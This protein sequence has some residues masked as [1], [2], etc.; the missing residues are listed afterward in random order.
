MNFIIVHVILLTWFIITS[1]GERWY[2]ATIIDKEQDNFIKTYNTDYLQAQDGFVPLT[3]KNFT[4]AIGAD[5]NKWNSKKKKHTDFNYADNLSTSV[6]AR[7]NAT[8]ILRYMNNVRIINVTNKKKPMRKLIRKR[9]R[10]IRQDKKLLGAGRAK[11]LEVFE[12][13]EF[14]HV[15]C[16]SSSGLEGTCLPEYECQNA[17][18]RPMGTCADGY[19]TCCVLEFKCDDRTSAAS[20]WFTNPSFPSPSTERL[21]CTLMIDKTSE[22]V[23]Q[24][25][26][27]FM[28]FE[29]LPP[30]DG[31]CQQ[32]QFIVSGQ[33]VNNVIPILCGVNT[34]Q[35]IYIEVAETDG[36]INLSFQT[37]SADTR[38]FSIKISQLTETDEL[39]GPTGCFQYFTEPQGILES[40]NYRDKSD[41]GIARIPEYLNNLNYAM[42]IN[43]ATQTCSITYTNSNYNMQIV[44]YDPDG[45]P[46]IP[47]GQAGVEI[48]NCPSDWL[49]ISATRL[50]GERLNDGSVIQDFSLDAPVTD[51]S[52]G[53][54]VVWFRS[55]EGYVGRG[56]QIR[57][58]Q[59]ACN[60]PS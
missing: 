11:F 8:A 18:G 49:L 19:G 3:M 51:S 24:I 10:P 40:F 42:C 38:L 22:N 26:L 47:K 35:H 5:L 58:Q 13:V 32:D 56:F 28:N 57:Y 43:R 4:E 54:I 7:P 60:D 46:V 36:P 21:S 30:T 16:T 12:V 31:T 17:S 48:F 55:D 1:D 53:P 50:C 37:V 41:I 52:A 33:N 34:G 39:A 25:R 15:V 27:D 59:N 9:C 29:L 2:S 6:T 23:K 45:L 14:D 20:G 44:N